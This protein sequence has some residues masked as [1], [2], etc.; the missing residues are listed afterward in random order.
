MTGA[1]SGQRVQLIEK[2]TE[3][4]H[5][6]ELHTALE[7]YRGEDLPGSIVAVRYPSED[8]RKGRVEIEFAEVTADADD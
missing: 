7:Q 1:E 8:A 6:S 2:Q 4:V 5:Y 3:E